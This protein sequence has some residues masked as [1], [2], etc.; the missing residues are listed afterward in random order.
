[1]RIKLKKG[2]QRE[3]IFLAKN[4]LTWTE[5]AKKLSV[6]PNYLSRDLK[7]EKR[8]ISDIV[9]SKLCEITNKN[10]D[11]FIL[12]ELGDNWGQS[13][14]GQNSNGSLVN[15]K[16]PEKDERL[17]E[18]IG[19][20]LGDGNI[21]HYK[22]GKKIGV[23]QVN[24][25]GDR[26]LDRDY[27]LIYIT[28]LFGDLF[29]I[30]VKEKLPP[31][32]NA[33]H[34]IISSRQL[35]DFLISQGLK[36]GD[37]IKNQVTIPY[38]IKENPLYL[39]ACLRGLFDTDGGIYELLPHWPGLYQISLTCYNPILMNDV[40]SGLVRLGINCSN[41]SR[42][43]IYITKKTE[44]IKFLKQIGFRNSRHL[45]KIDRWNL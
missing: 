44:L 38:W 9:Y 14:G 5:L 12:E 13:K 41:I 39:R 21:N 42:N 6:N 45:N 17:A 20:I 11:K 24:I 30:K 3:L 8:L 40:R 19:I 16:I 26:N 36:S 27:H 23:Y 28:S 15:I 10:F 29:E 2:K 25:A 32:K 22:K 31:K 43:R 33:R 18:L 1:M 35:V 7:Y 37:K 34:L 4:N